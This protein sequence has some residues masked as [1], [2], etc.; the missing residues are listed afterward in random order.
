[1]EK[2]GYDQHGRSRTMFPV[3]VVEPP[4][5]PARSHVLIEE[6][7]CDLLSGV[8]IATME[9]SQVRPTFEAPGVAGPLLLHASARTS[10]R[11]TPSSLSVHSYLKADKKLDPIWEP[12]ACQ[13]VDIL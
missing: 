7:D 9:R 3:P 12:F 5:K 8:R 6:L 10:W 2:M 11:P 4:V 1:M 13:D